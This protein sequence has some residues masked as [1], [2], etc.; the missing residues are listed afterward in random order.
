LIFATTSLFE[1][2]LWRG[3][4]LTS[5]RAGITIRITNWNTRWP[6]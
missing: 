4:R 6:V 5:S 2:E 1:P 3:I